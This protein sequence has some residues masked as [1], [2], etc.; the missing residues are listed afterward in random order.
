MILSVTWSLTHSVRGQARLRNSCEIALVFV[1][2]PHATWSCRK[3]G[4]TTPKKAVKR[5]SFVKLV[6]KTGGRG[7]HVKLSPVF[8][9]H[10]L[11]P[12]CI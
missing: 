5:N 8:Y 10:P 12:R 6:E 4:K 7:D 3:R 9:L 11:F 2:P 1:V